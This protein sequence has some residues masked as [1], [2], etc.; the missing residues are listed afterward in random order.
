MDNVKDVLRLCIWSWEILILLKMQLP[1]S[2]SL[3][4]VWQ[5]ISY[6]IWDYHDQLSYPPKINR[7]LKLN[8]PHKKDL[9]K[10]AN[11]DVSIHEKRKTLQKA[12]L[13][14]ALFATLENINIPSFKKK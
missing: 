10:I 11:E 13:G 6:S 8:F 5:T 9:R 14:E 1:N 3:L 2:Y 4:D 12:K 7:I